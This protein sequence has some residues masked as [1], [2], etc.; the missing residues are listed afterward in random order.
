MHRFV[1]ENDEDYLIETIDTLEFLTESDAL[2]DEEIDVVGE[3]LS[4]LY[5]AIEV[6]REVRQG[7]PEKEALNGF[8]QRVLGSIDK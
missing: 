4:N 2:K 6:S 8:M 3:L 5:A 7:T 1:Q